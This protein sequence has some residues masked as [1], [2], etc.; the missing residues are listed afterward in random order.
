MATLVTSLNNSLFIKHCK[1]WDINTV[2]KKKTLLTCTNSIYTNPDDDLF[3]A[4]TCSLKME[5][6]QGLYLNRVHVYW[7]SRLLFNFYQ[8]TNIGPSSLLE[9]S[10]KYLQTPLPPR[11][12]RTLL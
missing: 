9:I 6:E 11:G 7:I 8:N 5:I 4:G 1:L 3:I 2:Y 10:T 12:A